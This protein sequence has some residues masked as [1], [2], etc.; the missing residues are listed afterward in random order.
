MRIDRS[1]GGTTG[2][3]AGEPNNTQDKKPQV[4][5]K[6]QQ[7]QAQVDDVIFCFN[8]FSIFKDFQTNYI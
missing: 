5:K 1:Y 6:L 8:Y 7:T 3:T 2:Y 4:N